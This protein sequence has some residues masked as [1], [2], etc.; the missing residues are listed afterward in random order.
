[1]RTK[2]LRM[3]MV[4]HR[5]Q[6]RLPLHH[7]RL[8]TQRRRTVPVLVDNTTTRTIPIL[9]ALNSNT[10]TITRHNHNRHNQVVRTT[11]T[12]HTGNIRQDNS[13]QRHTMHP[14]H[15]REHCVLYL[16]LPRKSNHPLLLLNPNPHLRNLLPHP[17]NR[18]QTDMEEDT[19]EEYS[20]RMPRARDT[21]RTGM[22]LVR[23][24]I[25]IHPNLTQ[26]DT[27]ITMGTMEVDTRHYRRRRRRRTLVCPS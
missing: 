9:H 17:L 10:L 24:I 6:G 12:L 7:L 5:I 25:L 13:I 26:G 19:V 8:Q 18:L 1:M 23:D 2:E 15:R 3:D 16:I 21:I 20:H 4:H 14:Q 22:Q 11:L 27:R